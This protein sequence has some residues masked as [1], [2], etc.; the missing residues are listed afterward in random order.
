MAGHPREYMSRPFTIQWRLRHKIRV[1]RG[2]RRPSKPSTIAPMR[3]VLVP[4]LIA[5]A[6]LDLAFRMICFARARQALF[7]P[8]QL[9]GHLNALGLVIAT[10]ICVAASL[11]ARAR[12]ARRPG[13]RS[14]AGSARRRE[15]CGSTA[16][17]PNPDTDTV[18]AC[19]TSG[20]HL[21]RTTR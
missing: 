13:P 12:P 21:T 2:V 1:G 4:V 16:H 10:L 14:R 5:W 17:R 11:C 6:M 18:P 19:S 9:N 20:A 7:L 3:P 8:K 15:S